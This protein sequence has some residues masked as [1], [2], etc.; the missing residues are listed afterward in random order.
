MRINMPITD[1]EVILGDSDEIVSSSDLRGDI[2]FCNETFCRISGFSEEELAEQPHNIIRHPDMPASVFAGMWQQLKSGR[3]WMGIVKNRCKNG[4]YYWVNAYVT[5]VW[6]GN[7]ICG[8][9][10]VRVKAEPAW[11]HRANTLYQRL[12]AGKP[13]IRWLDRWR[14]RWG[15]PALFALGAWVLLAAC[16]SL[17]AD[18]SVRQILLAALPAVALS[19]LAHALQHQNVKAALKEAQEVI[20]DTLATHIYTGGISA[21]HRIALARLAIQYRLR[22]ALGRFR[23]SAG[24]V[25]HKSK[26]VNTFSQRTFNSMTEQQHETSLVA[27]TMEQMAIA[28]REVAS[29]ASH[30]SAATS[31]AAE[32]V[33]NSHQVVGAAQSAV[34]TLGQTVT[35]LD[36]M[37]SRLAEDNSQIAQVVGVIRGI[38]EQTNLLA[39]NAAIEAAR[40]GEQGRGFAV[41]ADEVRSLAQ[42]TQE[43]TEHIQTIIGNL[44]RATSDTRE[45]MNECLTAAEHSAD[46]MNHVHEALASIAE[47]VTR[48]DQMSHQIAAAAEE[49]STTA[50]EIQRN[51]RTIA[52]IAVATQTDIQT[53]EALGR[54][55]EQQTRKQQELVLRFY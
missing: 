7:T 37:I 40:A 4:D 35:E 50:V 12:N 55:M 49:Q 5:P 32:E 27:A 15:N 54:E 48:I 43:S 34:N 14:C 19:L 29:G 53:A 1:R 42:R 45:Q 31:M 30:T 17:T 44:G 25:Q 9:E 41:V 26:E 22:T 10:S 39:L 21:I 23:E 24:L 6:E 38:A 51:T 28:I 36:K 20:D 18:T 16:L 2:I 13:A 52:D 46:E 3:P 8:Y 11:I 47:A 33:K